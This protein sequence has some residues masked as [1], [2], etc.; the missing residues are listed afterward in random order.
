MSAG[1]RRSLACRPL[2]PSAG[3]AWVGLRLCTGEVA[4]A[5]DGPGET[6]KQL[7][8]EQLTRIDVTT[9]TKHAEPVG[10]AAGAISVITQED[11]RRSGVTTLADALRLATG[12]A[13]A[14]SDGH[15]WAVSTRG[16]NSPTANK[17]QVLIDGRIVYTPLFSGVQWDVQD[18]VL[19][20]V[21]RI[22]VIRGPGATLWGANA[23]AGTP[24]ACW[25]FLSSGTICCTRNTSSSEA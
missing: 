11:I 6:L 2:R 10:E 24:G 16:F 1:T 13:V 15:T 17:M 7:T 23:L 18:T 8:I 12:V 20:D 14:R 5:Q 3:A 9:V 19:E 25:S 4:E 22:E 21:D